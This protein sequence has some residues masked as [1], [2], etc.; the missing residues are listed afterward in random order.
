MRSHDELQ[1]AMV[2]VGASLADGIRQ[3]VWKGRPEAELG[4]RGAFLALGWVVGIDN[5]FEVDLA[6][7][8]AKLAEVM[9]PYQA[10][11]ELNDV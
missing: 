3:M 6:N 7:V 9:K 5:G 10:K 4:A 1:R 11:G 8:T 2:L